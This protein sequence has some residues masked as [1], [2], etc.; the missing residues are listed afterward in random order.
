M[1][2]SVSRRTD[3]PA[4]YS[5]WLVNRFKEGYIL[6]RN[7]MNHHQV[8]KVLLKPELIDCIVFWTKDPE[9]LIDK[10]ESFKEYPYYFHITINP[11]GEDVERR[12]RP[13]K[14]IIES[15]KRLC[16]LI[17]KDR[18]I[19]RYN[20]IIITDKYTLEYHSKY[21]AQLMK[22]LQPYCS[23]CVIS[24]LHLYDKT[25]RNMSDISYKDI[26]DEQK[27]EIGKMFAEIGN[28]YGMSI[29]TCSENI[30]LVTEGIKRGKCI[31]DELVGRLNNCTLSIPKDKNQRDSCD[32][33]ESI[34]IGAYNSC[35]HDCVYCYANYSEKSVSNNIRKH[36]P[37]SPF[38]IG[39]LE[40]E[41]VVKERKMVRFCN[42]YEQISLEL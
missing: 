31:D 3:I 7:P 33:V 29:E 40:T 35:Y 20:P 17:G 28:K 37:N 38:L 19:W 41:D 23:K 21:F 1:I 2:L 8:S 15:V 16:G 5:Q 26:S 32:C 12:V 11:Y 25:K 13:K 6:T 36:D 4:Y 9:N 39:E 34:D 42:G 24:F 10:L 22:M 27:M 14:D 30:N 18:I